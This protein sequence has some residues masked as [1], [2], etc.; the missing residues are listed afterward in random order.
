MAEAPT[1]SRAAPGI[2]GRTREG[3]ARP[4]QRPGG[5][6][7]LKET[8]RINADCLKAPYFGHLA[9]DTAHRDKPVPLRAPL[10]P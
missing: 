3:K 7:F 6:P 2:T 4:T 9:H 8:P 10:L 5:F 1:F